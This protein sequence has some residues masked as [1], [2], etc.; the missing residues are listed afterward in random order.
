MNTSFEIWLIDEHDD[1]ADVIEFDYPSINFVPRI[2][3]EISL[4]DDAWVG[5]SETLHRKHYSCKSVVKG[6][7]LSYDD[8]GTAYAYVFA[9]NRGE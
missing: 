9:E 6:V 7:I 8:M 5:T 3:D 2:G 4:P 1:I